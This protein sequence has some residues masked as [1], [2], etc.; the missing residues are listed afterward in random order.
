MP[1]A[2]ALAPA[3]PSAPGAAAASVEEA[4]RA[5][6]ALA[7]RLEGAGFAGWDPYDALTSPLVRPLARTPLAR[8]VALQTLKWSPVNLRPLLGVAPRRHT[9]ALAL[10]ASA[11]GRLGRLDVA[12]ELVDLLLEHGVRSGGGVG[13]GYDFDVETR[14]GSYRAGVPN[15]IA[16]AFA[17]QAAADAGR[18]DI[19]RQ[20]V[21]FACARLLVDRAGEPF[22]GYYE[23][24]AKPIH[25]A[26]V[27]VAAAAALCGDDDQRLLARRALDYTLERQ[28]PDGS[29]PY[30]ESP[31][32]GWVDGFHTAYVLEGL[33]RW[34]AHEPEPAVRAAIERGTGLFVDRLVDVDGA[35]RAT[36]DSRYPIDTHAAASAITALCAVRGHDARAL[37]AAERVLSFALRRLRRRDA[38]FRFQLHRGWRSSIPYVRWSDAHMLLALANYLATADGGDN[39]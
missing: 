3:R 39:P 29:W 18:P 26:N 14:W 20:A 12:S 13:F 24:S 25:N 11:Y 28:R 22:F 31:G 7:S 2:P 9:K 23:G 21:T 6:E 8:R 37:P 36:L 16:T 30:G 34:E 5:A 27:L 15:A 10:L 33:A 17:A 38:R 35:P 4:R 19:G 32:L 1:G